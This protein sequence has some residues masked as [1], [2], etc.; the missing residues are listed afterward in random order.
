MSHAHTLAASFGET[1]KAA[2]EA[3]REA[4]TAIFILVDV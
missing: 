3:K 2:A 1:E 4:I